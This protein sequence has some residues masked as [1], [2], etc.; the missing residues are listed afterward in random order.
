MPG[1]PS[2]PLG[3]SASAEAGLVLTPFRALRYDS[4]R[5]SSLAAVLSPPYDVID[6]QDARALARLDPHN[7]IRLILPREDECGPEG[8]YEHAAGTLRTWIADGTLRRDLDPAL[9]VLEQ[10]AGESRYHGVLGAL[11]LRAPQDG[12][13]LPHENVMP[14][15][16][17]DR[18][19]LL[20]ATE[21]NLEPIFLVYEGGGVASTVIDQ[22]RQEPPLVTTTTLDGITHRL[23]A[24]SDPDRLAAIAH[25]LRPRQALIAD[26]HHRYAACLRYQ[27]ERRGR[28]GP[29]P[30]D[31]AL[32]L[33][34]DVETAAPQ[35]T[36]IS[37]VVPGLSFDEALRAAEPVARI[38]T[39]S[40]APVDVVRQWL[41]LDGDPSSSDPPAMAVFGGDRAALLSVAA[42]EY[43]AATTAEFLHDELLGKRWHRGNGNTDVWYVHDIEDAVRRAA[44]ANGVAI[45]LRP[46]TVP[47]ILTVAR[48]GRTMP[49]KSTSFGPKPPDGLV[50]RTLSET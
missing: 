27:R 17:A 24:I 7:I 3:Q 45:A 33:L 44:Q 19:G 9:Y 2:A 50:L 15:P 46:P 26:G 28:M 41:S 36:S 39:V 35:L 37:Q 20:R 47:Q 38:T 25:D 29:G 40:A 16:V 30:W 6:D 12:V 14:E 31:R 4:A 18:L 5:V 42:D 10:Q 13:V 43:G 23:W 8:P 49:R 11:E 32:S 22:A 48:S 21:A 1:M 34:V